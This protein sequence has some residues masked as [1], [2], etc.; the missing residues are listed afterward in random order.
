MFVDKTPNKVVPAAASEL[1]T[2][3]PWGSC[4][5]ENRICYSRGKLGTSIALEYM[6]SIGWFVSRRVV[7]YIVSF[8]DFSIVVDV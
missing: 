3:L 4:N 5:Y 2:W 8:G 6:A 1:L 7:K